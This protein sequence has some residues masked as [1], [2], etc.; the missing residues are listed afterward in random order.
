MRVNGRNYLI[1]VGAQ[2]PSEA[3]GSAVTLDVDVVLG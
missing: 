1:P 2:I 3:Y